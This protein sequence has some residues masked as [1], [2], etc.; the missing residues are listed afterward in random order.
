MDLQSV[1]GT[2]PDQCEISSF[3]LDLE[4]YSDLGFISRL[5]MFFEARHVQS[6]VKPWSLNE[7]ESHRTLRQW[8]FPGAWRF[9]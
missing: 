3:A 5:Q 9:R 6:C 4:S 8:L 2:N 7:S 1:D